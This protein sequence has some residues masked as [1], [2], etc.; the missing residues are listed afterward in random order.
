MRRRFSW[1]SLWL[2]FSPLSQCWVIV[3]R[4]SNIYMPVMF[5]YCSQFCVWYSYFF[6]LLF[7][8]F[9]NFLY[10]SIWTAYTEIL[11]PG[12]GDFLLLL[13]TNSWANQNY[14]PIRPFIRALDLCSFISFRDW[15]PINVFLAA[16]DAKACARLEDRRRAICRCV[17]GILNGLTI[18]MANRVGWG[19]IMVLPFVPSLI[20]SEVGVA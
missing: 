17:H 13:S 19:W 6:F 3:S 4:C 1:I 9:F 8:L 5:S 16:V 7:F 20:S 2:M 14:L 15:L 10:T 11:Q 18:G 12:G